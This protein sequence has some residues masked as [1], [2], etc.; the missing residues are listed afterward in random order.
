MVCFV[1]ESHEES[2][3][4]TTDKALDYSHSGATVLS[5]GLVGI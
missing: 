3:L 2:I 5:R 1:S 4:I